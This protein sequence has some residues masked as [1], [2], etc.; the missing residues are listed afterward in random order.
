MYKISSKRPALSRDEQAAF[1]PWFLDRVIRV[2]I[3]KLLPRY[4]YFRLRL[5]FDK[6]GCIC[7]HRKDRAYG[8]NGLCRACN[9]TVCERLRLM[10]A[11]LQRQFKRENDGVERT[12]LRRL[13]NAKRLLGDIKAI[14]GK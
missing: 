10:D 14:L 1:C 8:S 3:N 11:R 7:C 4:Y 13:E 9:W 6:Y 2:R 5:Y 12:F